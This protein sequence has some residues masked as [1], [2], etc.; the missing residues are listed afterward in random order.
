MYNFVFFILIFYFIKLT[1]HKK[2]YNSQLFLVKIQSYIPIIHLS[3]CSSKIA[4]IGRVTTQK[5]HCM[6]KKYCPLNSYIATH[7]KRENA[8]WRVSRFS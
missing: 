1:S 8:Y 4:V 7:Y 5:L 6:S 3:V 2:I